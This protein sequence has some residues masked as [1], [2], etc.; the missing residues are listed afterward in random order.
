MQG[1]ILNTFAKIEPPLHKESQI[2]YL[3]S[4]IRRLLDY[5][6][7]RHRAACRVLGMAEITAHGLSLPL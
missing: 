5:L 4:D 1:L 2:H 7:V 6:R 3:L